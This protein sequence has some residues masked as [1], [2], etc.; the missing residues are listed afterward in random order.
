MEDEDYKNKKIAYQE[1]EKCVEEIKKQIAKATKIADDAGLE[2][3]F[4]L[5]KLL[6]EYYGKGSPEW[7]SSNDCE[8]QDG[9]DEPRF[10]SEWKF[11]L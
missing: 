4:N 5:D 3:R 9:R 10:Q 2:F 1:V 6:I 11:K 8:W 7:I